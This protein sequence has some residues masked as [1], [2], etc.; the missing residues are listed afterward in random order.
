MKIGG[1]WSDA[2]ASQGLM[3]TTEKLGGGREGFHTVSQRDLDF[4][5]LAC[6]TGRGEIYLVLSHP[7][8]YGSLRKLIK[9]INII[10]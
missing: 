8:C 4:R 1:G 3:V 10:L 7:V 6:T 5:L 2:A 9:C